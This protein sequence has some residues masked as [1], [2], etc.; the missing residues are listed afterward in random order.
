MMH[1][2]NFKC[3]WPDKVWL[4]FTYYGQNEILGQVRHDTQEIAALPPIARN[5][6][7]W[8]LT[9]PLDRGKVAQQGENHVLEIGGRP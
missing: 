3:P 4:R 8:G 6:K 2:T 5:D 1:P 9:K 7:K